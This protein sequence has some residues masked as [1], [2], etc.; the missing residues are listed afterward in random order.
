MAAAATA[1]SLIIG[2]RQLVKFIG[3]SRAN[4][5]QVAEL[6]TSEPV[7]RDSGNFAAAW[8]SL[9]KAALLDPSRGDVRRAQE[10]LAMAWLENIRLSGEGAKFFD[11]VDKVTPV[12]SLAATAADPSRKADA[13]AHLGWA[14]FL[15]SRDGVGGLD[16][17]ASY[18][19]ALAAD[20][21][22]VYA[23]AMLGHSILWR[24]GTL[25]EA[26][27]SFEAALATG[28]ARQYVRGLQLSA[29]FNRRSEE[30]ED[31]AVR[32]AN[33]MRK[34][35]ETL[36]ARER[37]FPIYYD[38]VRAPQPSAAFL[39]LLPPEE[40]LATFRWLFDAGTLDEGRR[41]VAQYWLATLEEASGQ[42]REAL[43]EFRS[44]RS[45]VS[46]TGPSPLHDSAEAGV[47]RLSKR[48]LQEPN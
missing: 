36:G 2:I 20:P 12:L 37:F 31:E 34:G 28:R 43:Q 1:V 7:Q 42:P 40:H 11:I 4:R 19:K 13:L 33:E 15:R 32:V 38:R 39:T 3:D 5:R 16:P 45:K 35:S 41:L 21:R 23:Q 26:R 14:D 47:K 17:E 10:D 25:L 8:A 22:N 27:R 48:L 30:A 18:H 6:L 29:L 24:G 9:E 44:L 46:G